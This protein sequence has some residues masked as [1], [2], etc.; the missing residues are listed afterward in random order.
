MKQLWTLKAIMAKRAKYGICMVSAFCIDCD[1]IK[2]FPSIYNPSQ[3]A[4]NKTSSHFL[5]GTA[6]LDRL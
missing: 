5:E 6:Q 2:T 1:Y 4:V 3:P